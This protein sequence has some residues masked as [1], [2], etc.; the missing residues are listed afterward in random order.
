MLDLLKAL[1]GSLISSL[2]TRH[3]L[4][5]EKLALRQQIGVLRRSVKR[6]RL[7]NADRAFWVVLRRW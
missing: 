3:E 2:H 1:L 6:P 5:L 7:S 4:A